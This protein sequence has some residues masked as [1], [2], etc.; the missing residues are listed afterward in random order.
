MSRFDARRGPRILLVAVALF[1]AG[2]GQVFCSVTESFNDCM[3][4]GERPDG[5]YACVDSWECSGAFRSPT[6]Y[7]VRCTAT[8]GG[9]R[10]C[11]CFE[12]GAPGRQVEPT[13]WCTLGPPDGYERIIDANAQ[14]G[15]SMNT[16]RI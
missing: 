1:A 15:W 7:Q 16:C 11:R 12:G 6:V 8:D 3:P 10:D 14:C 2:C 4:G 9:G 13:P 5:G